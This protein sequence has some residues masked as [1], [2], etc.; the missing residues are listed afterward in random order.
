MMHHFSKT[1]CQYAFLLV[2]TLI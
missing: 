2:M 1:F